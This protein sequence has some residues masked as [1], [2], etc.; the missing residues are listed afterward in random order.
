MVKPNTTVLGC[1]YLRHKGK[2]GKLTV[3]F[4]YFVLVLD[5]M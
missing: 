3:L 4:S 2:R 1:G 5:L